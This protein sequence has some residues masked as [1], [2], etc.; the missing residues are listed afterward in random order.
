MKKLAIL[1]SVLVLAFALAGCQR[2]ADKVA[3]N[4]SKEADN[5]NVVRQ[6]TV[7][8][9]RTDKILFQM[10]G[11]MSYENEGDRITVIV[12]DENGVYHKHFIALNDWVTYIIEDKGKAKINKYKYE[13]NFNPN[14]FIPVTGKVSD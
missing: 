14:M 12:E 8:N 7:I 11:K 6:L 9:C 10:T 13:L 5:F 4:V 1:I 2:E 3:Y